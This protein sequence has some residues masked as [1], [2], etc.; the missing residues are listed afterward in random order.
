MDNHYQQALIDHVNITNLDL[1]SRDLPAELKQPI[2]SVVLEHDDIGL[3]VAFSAMAFNYQERIIYEYQLGDGQ[4]TYTRNNNRVLFPKLSAGKYHLK[5]WAK[6]PLTGELTPPAI[7][8][9]EVILQ[10]E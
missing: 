1:M 5:V 2:D 8:N 6:D 4:K 3:E 9:I 7:L 10:I